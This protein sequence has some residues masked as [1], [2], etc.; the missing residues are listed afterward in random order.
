MKA[1]REKEPNTRSHMLLS[2]SK[3]FKGTVGNIYTFKHRISCTNIFF[4]D[5]FVKAKVL[6]NTDQVGHQNMANSADI[7]SLHLKRNPQEGSS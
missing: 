6:S 2:L 3:G 1:W 4:T 7:Y 5:I